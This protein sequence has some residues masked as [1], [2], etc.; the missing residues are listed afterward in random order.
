MEFN[1]SKCQ[2]M[3]VTSSK[4]LFNIVY[5]LHGQVLEVVT[6]AKYLGLTFPVAYPGIP[7]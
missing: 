3:R 6:S 2:V 1:L 4:T 7:A 5:S